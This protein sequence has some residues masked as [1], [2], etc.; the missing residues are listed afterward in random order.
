MGKLAIPKGKSFSFDII[1]YKSNS[2]ELEDLTTLDTD[3]S[4]FYLLEPETDTPIKGINLAV[5]DATHGV[6][7]I[8]IPSSVSSKLIVRKGSKVD[9]YYLKPSYMGF[10]NLTFTDDTED[11]FTKI[12]KVYVVES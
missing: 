8:T 4:E 6:I 9:W 3:N 10:L 7:T 11:R 5:K 12:D 2:N 1:I